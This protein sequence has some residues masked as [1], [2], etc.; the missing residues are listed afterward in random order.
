MTLAFADSDHKLDVDTLAALEPLTR[1]ITA[2][3]LNPGDHFILHS[4]VAQVLFLHE[5]EDRV[6]IVAAD[7]DL[8]VEFLIWSID[9]KIDLLEE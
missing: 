3:E 1:E 8:L 7:S 6:Y 4:V 9:L 2:K 5:T